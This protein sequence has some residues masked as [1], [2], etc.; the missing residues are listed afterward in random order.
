MADLARTG[1]QTRPDIAGGSRRAL[2]LL[3]QFAL[4]LFDEHGDQLRREQLLLQARQ[5]ARFNHM[6]VDPA[7]I[8]ARATA[9]VPRT[10]ELRSALRNVRS[11]ATTAVDEAG[12][13]IFGPVRA[14]ERAPD[15]IAA[16][17][18]CQ[19]RLPR[20]DL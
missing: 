6:A 10:G 15:F 17:P 12:E 8:V 2:R 9:T 13:E 11:T 16:N 19:I 7:S 20:L 5:N 14:V 18:E 1:L 3:G 4:E